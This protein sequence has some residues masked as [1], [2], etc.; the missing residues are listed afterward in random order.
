MKKKTSDGRIAIY[1]RKPKDTKRNRFHHLIINGEHSV[2]FFNDNGK[3]NGTANGLEIVEYIDENELEKLAEVYE[4]EYTKED[5]ESLKGS[6]NY[7]DGARVE[8]LTRGYF[9][10][11]KDGY[12]KAKEE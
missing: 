3:E 7:E 12:R 10:G 8:G 6:L 9:D 11:F 2:V 4:Y 1:F 5:Y